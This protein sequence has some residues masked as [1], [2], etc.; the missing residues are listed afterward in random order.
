MQTFR[1]T[2]I[3]H[4]QIF[5]NYGLEDEIEDIVKEA[6]LRHEFVE[7]YVGRNGD[8]DI[9]AASAVK[10]AQKAV[11]EKNSSLILVEPYKM[12]DDMYYEKFYETILYPVKTHPKSAI[13]ERNRWM[14]ERAD[15]VIA[16]VE[17]EKKGGAYTALKYATSLG[18]EIINL[19]MRAPEKAE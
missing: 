17:S 11:G 13:T 3:G 5:G 2:F 9:L 14:I 7:L 10:R 19:A 15:L 12:K 8:F 16:F 4:R 18:T 6:L 1:I